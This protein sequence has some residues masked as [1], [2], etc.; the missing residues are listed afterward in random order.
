M[1]QAAEGSRQLRD[2]LM[3]LDDGGRQLVDGTGRLV[4]G[5]E[6]VGNVVKGISENVRD[7]TGALP[8][9]G[10][11]HPSGRRNRSRPA[12][13][14]AAGDRVAAKR[15]W[16]Y[17]LIALGAVALAAAALLPAGARPAAA[18]RTGPRCGLDRTG[19]CPSDLA[20]AD[21]VT[22][23]GQATAAAQIPL[24]AVQVAGELARPR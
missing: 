1:S 4:G 13:Q 16:P 20:A 2:G 11:R 24:P 12:H 8:A 7:A 19:R 9:P 22:L 17:A 21:L 10:S 5:V 3:Q 23:G 14:D 15:W 18:G 6:P